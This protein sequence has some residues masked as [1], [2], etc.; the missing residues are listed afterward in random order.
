MRDINWILFINT[1]SIEAY[2]ECQ[3]QL[4][5]DR[6]KT[7]GGLGAIHQI[8]KKK[9]KKETQTQNKKQNKKKNPTG[10]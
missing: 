2:R 7:A 5:F 8:Q 4:L 3:Q 6:V 9:K 1:C 10:V